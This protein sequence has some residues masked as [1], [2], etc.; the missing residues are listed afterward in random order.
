MTFLPIVYNIIILVHMP[1][2]YSKKND[3]ILN[4]V[5]NR[6]KSLHFKIDSFF[7]LFGASFIVWFLVTGFL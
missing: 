3:F 2:S 5:F 4:G 7:Y 1:Y 6:I